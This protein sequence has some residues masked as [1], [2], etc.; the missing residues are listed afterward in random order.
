MSPDGIDQPADCPIAAGRKLVEP[1]PK[2]VNAVERPPEHGPRCDG[3][4]PVAGRPQPPAEGRRHSPLGVAKPQG[5]LLRRRNDPLGR[6]AG[7]RGTHV[8]HEI[9]QRHVDLMSNGR[10]HG[11]PR[12]VDR[13][14]HDLLVERPEVFEAPAAAGHDQAVDRHG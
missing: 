14:A 3:L 10:D 2:I 12:G 9:G 4:Q 11:N 13:P 6:L 7:G 5:D 8:G 1:P